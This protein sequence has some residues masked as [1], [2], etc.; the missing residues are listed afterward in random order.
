MKRF[1]LT[2]LL[3]FILPCAIAQQAV[4][5]DDMIEERNFMPFELTYLTDTTNT[6]SFEHVSSAALA[7]HFHQ[8]TSYQ[9]SDF[10][11][12][13]AYWIRLPIRH[14]GATRKLWLLEFYDQTIDHIEAYIPQENGGYKK[15]LLGDRQ[16]FE[17]RLFLHKNFEI[18][19]NM[20]SDTTM[21]YYF[22]VRS[23]GF[24][25]IR[26]A[27]RSVNRFIYYALNEYF[28][29]GTFY[30]MIIIIALYNFLVYTAIREVKN[31]YYI[32]YIL[33]VAAYAMSYDGIGF[34]Y[35][36]PSH[37]EFNN[38]ATGITLFSVI[39]W[40]LIF[41]RRFL[42]TRAN[43]PT[44]DLA[45]RWMIAIRTAV[46]VIELFFFPEYLA[47]R[48]IEIIPLSLIFYTGISALRRGYRPARFFV[49]AYGILFLGFFIRTMVYFDLLPFTTALHYSLH[50]SFVLEMLFLTFALGDRIRIL[51]DMRDR[52][53]KRTIHQHEVNMQLKDKVNRELEDKVRGRTIALNEKNSELEEM[54][55]KLER[56]AQQINQINSILDLDNWKLKNSIKEVLS[57]RLHEK[58]MDYKQFQ[59][60]Y[61]D[62]LACYRFLE[63]LKWE[64]GFACRKCKN[65]KYFDGA[66]KFARRCTRCGYNESI[67]AYTIF[68]SIKFPIEKAFY[69][70]YLVVSD[71]RDQTLEML[72]TQLDLRVNTVWGFKHKV[73]EKLELLKQKGHRLSAS[74][75][76]E[77]ILNSQSA[78]RE[79]SGKRVESI[80]AE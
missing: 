20:R 29:F 13:A 28:L 33:S 35:L 40:S 62:S 61:P 73:M 11:P 26:I 71:K 53:M 5:I 37:P 34:Q 6:L 47:Y 59:T 70:A 22:K 64:K 79:K 16:P 41:T 38:Y 18:T 52:A 78:K 30:G 67:T 55:Q 1:W 19:L 77:V 39:L 60:L 15:V 10:L 24:A 2:L 8:H 14:T 17:E 50:F 74:R 65:D 72:A 68:H 7:S 43:A 75:W 56:Q 44:L 76:Q 4:A 23:T 66:Q 12:S 49:I 51:K 27:L 32:M 3:F 80:I 58:T 54:N 9:N 31:I 57:E 21:Y 69:L 42:S 36:W 45:L 25:D 48:T 46:F 63:T